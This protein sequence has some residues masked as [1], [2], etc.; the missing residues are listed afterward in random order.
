MTAAAL[1][2]YGVL[3]AAAVVAVFRR[4]HGRALRLRPRPAAAQ[5]RHVA[6]LR[7]RRA[8]PRARRDPGVEGDRARG[9]ARL[10]RGR[11]VTRA[12]PAVPPELSSTALALAYARDRRPLRGDPAERAR[13]PRR[14]AGDRLRPA[15]RPRLRRRVLPRAIAAVSTFGAIALGDRR[16]RGRRRRLGPDRGLR[17][18]DRVV[19]PL[20][21]GRLLPPRARL[22]LPRARP[23]CR[24]TSP[25][26]RATASSGGSSRRSSRRSRPRTCS[27]IAL[28]LLA[29]TRRRGPARDRARRSS[30]APACSGRSRARRSSRS[31]VGLLVLAVARRRWWPAAAAVG[32][33]VAVGFAFASVFHDIAPRTHWFKSDLPYQEAQAQAKGPLPTDSGL[34]GT[35]SIGEPSIKSH[36]ESLKAGIRTVTHHPQGYGL[37]N[38]GTTA[39]RFG[40]KLEAG[41]SNYTELGA[42]TGIA[43][44][45]PLHR[46]EPRRSSSR[47]SARAW[48]GDRAAAARRR[49]RSPRRSRSLSRPTQSACPGSRTVSSGWQGSLIDDGRRETWPDDHLAR[50]VHRRRRAGD[51]LLHRAAR[52]SRSRRA[53]MGDFQYQMLKKGDR[54]HAGFVAK[55]TE[56][57]RRPIHWYPYI[58]RRRRRRGRREGEASSARR[59]YHGADGRRREPPLRRARRPAARD[60]RA[61]VVGAGA[62]AGPLRLGRAARGRRRRGEELLRRG[63][64]L[65]DRA[66]HGGLR[67]VQRRRDDG[68]RPDAGAER[69][70]GR[71]LARRT[72]RSTTPTPSPRRRWSSA[73]A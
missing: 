60:L 3:L 45:A 66:V 39:Q 26:T 19:A 70:A 5:H 33:R 68:R 37:G 48:R 41:E 23:A 28:L 8:R 2:V 46:L 12:P 64:R 54:T 17:R 32:R 29:T 18:A 44:R 16:R 49:R 10:G 22:R 62:A 13:R 11:A 38:A 43:R 56:A 52:A 1:V 53:D 15:P 59:S 27:S 58:Q 24:R 4:P 57:P 67:G 73:P 21:R 7:R 65:D 36:W 55:P 40:V 20:R 61:H 25:S 34:S 47:C 71:L 42:E 30:A 31:P 14:R 72:S 50:A 51:A 6:P 9:R 35:Y 63:R 69:L